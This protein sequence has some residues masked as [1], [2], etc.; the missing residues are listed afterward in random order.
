LKVAFY[1]D[2]YCD[3]RNNVE[4]CDY[5]GGVSAGKRE[6]AF[7][8]AITCAHAHDASATAHGGVVD[9]PGLL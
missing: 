1:G 3:A 4:T 7:V 9:V 2:G 6:G 8:S 5:D